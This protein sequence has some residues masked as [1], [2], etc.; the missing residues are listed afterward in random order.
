M[1]DQAIN[2]IQH[3]A[4]QLGLAVTHLWPEM[5]LR[6]WIQSLINVVVEVLLITA[7]IIASVITVKKITRYHQAQQDQYTEALRSQRS[8]VSHMDYETIGADL[9][10]GSILLGCLVFIIAP[11]FGLSNDVSN[12]FAPEAG[13][14]MRL[15]GK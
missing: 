15:L 8:Y 4:D 14:A 9:V 7:S 5:V 6:F 13:L 1:S 3:I 10:A 2:L 11:L 12:V